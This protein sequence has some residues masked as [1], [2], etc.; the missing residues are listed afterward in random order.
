MNVVDGEKHGVKLELR[1]CSTCK[2]MKIAKG[3]HCAMFPFSFNRNQLNALFVFHGIIKFSQV[4]RHRIFRH[5]LFIFTPA[6]H[7]F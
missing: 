1:F 2:G 7:F 3:E 6:I 4:I 5:F